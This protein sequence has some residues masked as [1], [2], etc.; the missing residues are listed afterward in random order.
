MNGEDPMDAGL[1]EYVQHG[2]ERKFGADIIASWE[3]C[4]Q[5]GLHPYERNLPPLIGDPELRRRSARRGEIVELFSF[6]IRR[7]AGLL[8]DL[9]ACSFVCDD[10]GYILS[11]AGHGKTVSYFDR[12][13]LREGASC[14]EVECLTF[15]LATDLDHHGWQFAQNHMHEAALVLAAARS[16]GVNS[17]F[18]THLPAKALSNSGIVSRKYWLPTRSSLLGS[19]LP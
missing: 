8:D 5:A 11:R 1:S 13:S 18:Q 7:F 15:S 16:H 6:Y 3:R 10:A 2:R 19:T 14:G 4:T 9:G 12:V 17:L